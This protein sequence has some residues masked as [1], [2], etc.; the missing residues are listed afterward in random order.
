MTRWRWQAWFAVASALAV[1]VV[2]APMFFGEPLL[3]SGDPHVYEAQMELLFAG[4]LPYSDFRFEHLPLTI[5]PMA[6]AYAVSTATG[7]GYAWVLLVVNMA[8]VFATSSFVVRV[9]DAL[10]IAGAG[11][12]FAVMA[13]P[14]LLIIPFRLDALSALLAVAAVSYAV[15]GRSARSAAAAAGAIAAKGWPVVLAATDWWRGER[16]R[17]QLL[18]GFAVVVGVLMLALPGF[19]AGRSFGGV[20]QETITGSIL[21]VFRLLTGSDPGIVHTAGAEYVEAGMYAILA[22]IAVGAAIAIAA[23]PVLRKPFDWTGGIA[24]AAALTYAVLLASP[25]LSAQFVWWPLPFVALVA[26][27]RGQITL[28]LAAGISVALVALWSPEALWWHSGWLVRNGLLVASAVFAVTDVRRIS[29]RRPA[30]RAR[31]QAA[32][33]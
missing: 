13:A 28:T 20:H 25:L 27:R 4:E 1:A 15:E 21:V 11:H 12:R 17:A 16:R 9:A 31:P 19:R 23:L 22:N 10:G 24:L 33:P 14:M 32:A 6:S 30:H 29:S 7:L 2:V 5:V 3:N 26:R 8:M 18:V